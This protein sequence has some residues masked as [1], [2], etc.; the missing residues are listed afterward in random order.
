MT[1]TL[2]RNGR[3]FDGTS[4]EVAV[5][6]VVL[7]G[8]RIAEVGVGLDGD[9]VI[10][11]AGKLLTPGLFD[12]HVHF[13][14]DGDF[15]AKTHLATPFSLNFF[16]AAERMGRTLD[17]GVTTVREA[18]G[19]DAGVREA[20]E[21]GLIRGPRT[22]LSLTMLSQTGGHGDSWEICGSH[23]PGMSDPHPGRPDNV[24]DGPEAMRKKVRELIRAGA[25]VIKVATSGGVISPRSDPRHAHFRPDELDMLVAE[26]TAAGRFVMA[27]AQG[28]PGIRNAVAA[29]I[30]SIEH[31]IYLD[32][33]VIEMML[34]AG[35]FLVPTLIAPLGVLDAVDKGFDLPDFVV[36]KATEVVEIHRASVQQAIGAGVPIAMGT[37]SGVTPHGENLRELSEMADLGMSPVE[38]L[39]AS[40]SV[41]ADLLGIAEEVGTIEPGKIADLVVWDGDDLN[42][43]DM[44]S[45]LSTVV[46][47]GAVVASPD[48]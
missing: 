1:R 2:L 32:E 42:V 44:R 11:C 15:S 14:V 45:R 22:L 43:S 16:Q 46:Q 9:Q 19:S 7:E 8:E 25:D 30:R 34:E 48:G 17:I 24:V 41:A 47:S 18:G 23:M 3:L 31:G 27:H 29:G 39:R 35:T 26:A 36:A 40:T 37:D 20:Q 12:C 4:D 38:V 13:M 33:E 10:D 6:D 21:R 28:N 5:A